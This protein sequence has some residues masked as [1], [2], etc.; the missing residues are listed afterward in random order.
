MNATTTRADL[1]AAII[2][3]PDCDDLRLVYA[4]FVQDGGD[5]A[6]AEFIRVQ[7]KLAGV[8]C[9]NFRCVDGVCR[10]DDGDGRIDEWDCRCGRAALRQRERELWAE[11]ARV[12]GWDDLWS[13]FAGFVLAL[14][15]SPDEMT[16]IVRRGFVE[17]VTLSSPEWVA[18]ADALCAATP[19]REVRLTTW[20]DIYVSKM[21]GRT[22][23]K[24]KAAEINSSRMVVWYERHNQVPV[25]RDLLAAQWPRITFTLP[26]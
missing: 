17:A 9:D 19:L 4:D 2:T 15:S 26:E 10:A 5:E 13:S 22:L 24:V 18:Y 11:S 23:N 12:G 14:D 6:R 16:G 7:V 21:G 1:L 3:D 20:P 8:L 25:V